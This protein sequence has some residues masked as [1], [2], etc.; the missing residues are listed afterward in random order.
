MCSGSYIACTMSISQAQDDCTTNFKTRLQEPDGINEAKMSR[1]CNDPTFGGLHACR[2]LHQRKECFSPAQCQCS[3]QYAKY[4]G[5]KCL[6]LS[7]FD[8]FPFILGHSDGS[9][10]A[11]SD[12]ACQGC[13]SSCEHQCV[14]EW[15]GLDQGGRY[16]ACINK[17]RKVN[18]TERFAQL[19][20]QDGCTSEECGILEPSCNQTELLCAPEYLECQG[21]QAYIQSTLMSVC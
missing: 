19:C 3:Q 16:S 4:V 8:S 14:A 12:T 21:R 9:F 2:Y 17:C 13:S 11:S 15:G 18:T 1:T 20:V 10:A 5:P 7:T 6:D